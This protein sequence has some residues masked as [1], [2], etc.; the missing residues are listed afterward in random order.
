MQNATK[1]TNEMIEAM[2]FGKMI[3]LY[4]ILVLIL[5]W[6]GFAWFIWY[7]WKALRGK[8]V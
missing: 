4:G 8:D 2:A 6:I 1:V 3:E 5:L 7:M